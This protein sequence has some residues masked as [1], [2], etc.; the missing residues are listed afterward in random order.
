VQLDSALPWLALCL[1][2]GIAARL[3]AR[4]LKQFGSPE[5]VFRPPL[6]QLQACE[7]PSATA[8]AI[9]KKKAFKRAE[10]ELAAIGAISGC[11]LLNWSEPEYADTGSGYSDQAGAT[12]G[13]AAKLDGRGIANRKRAKN[14]RAAEFG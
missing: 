9:V 2:R 14:I 7:L 3:S 13:R 11:T 5:E 12:S 4:L 8:Q 10:K 1:T 6:R